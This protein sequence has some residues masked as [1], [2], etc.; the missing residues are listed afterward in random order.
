MMSGSGIAPGPFICNRNWALNFRSILNLN[1]T[2]LIVGCDNKIKRSFTYLPNGQ[3]SGQRS[4][5]LWYIL[6]LLCIMKSDRIDQPWKWI[7]SRPK[8][9]MI[10]SPVAVS[11]LGSVHTLVLH[12][13]NVQPIPYRSMSPAPSS[14]L[15]CPANGAG[16]GAVCTHII[17]R[18]CFTS[19]KINKLRW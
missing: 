2:L 16:A 11:L 14:T 7:F 6:I 4:G 12:P 9:C 17:L 19:L 3:F 10:G 1:W 18:W 5:K 15:H 8:A 13:I